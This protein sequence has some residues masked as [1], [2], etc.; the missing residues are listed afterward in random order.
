M[1]E[2]GA[3]QL[4]VRILCTALG[5]FAVIVKEDTVSD[6]STER[7]MQIAQLA[8]ECCHIHATDAEAAPVPVSAPAPDR[9]DLH[10]HRAVAIVSIIK[11]RGDCLPRDLAA[12]GYTP[13]DIA[14]CWPLARALAD[15]MLHRMEA[16]PCLAL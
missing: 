16:S 7:A 2:A 1:S 9:F 5:F 4:D 14:R 10:Q 11:D 8:E 13:D 15:V 6:G 12:K 3:A